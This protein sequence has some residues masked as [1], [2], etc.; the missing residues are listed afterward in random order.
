MTPTVDYPNNTCETPH[1]RNLKTTMLII[2]NSMI[3]IKHV[4]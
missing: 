3:E 1:H 2:V 4:H